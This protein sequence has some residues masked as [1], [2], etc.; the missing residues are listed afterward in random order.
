MHTLRVV[1][2]LGSRK[3]SWEKVGIEFWAT[4]QVCAQIRSSGQASV[5]ENMNFRWSFERLN[6]LGRAKKLL[7]W[8]RSSEWRVARV[9]CIL[10]LGLKDGSSEQKYRLERRS[11]CVSSLEWSGTSFERTVFCLWRWDLGRANKKESFS[12]WCSMRGSLKRI[13]DRSSDHC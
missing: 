8:V 4:F 13:N 2:W 10:P 7:S 12:E 3:V 5:F 1:I 9:N 11:F 6:T